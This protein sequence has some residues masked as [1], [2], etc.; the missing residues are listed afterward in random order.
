MVLQ[1]M[2][3]DLGHRVRGL[4]VRERLLGGSVSLLVYRVNDGGE[5][6]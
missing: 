5:G 3:R 6:T 4:S 1:K 2:T